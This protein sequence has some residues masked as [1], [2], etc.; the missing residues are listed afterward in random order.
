MKFILEYSCIEVCQKYL[1]M[2]LPHLAFYNN[3]TRLLLLYSDSIRRTEKVAITVFFQ[4]K[5]S[6]GGN[7]YLV[8]VTKIWY[9]ILIFLLEILNSP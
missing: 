6:C 7:Q 4:R 5:D 1:L 9:P 8:S 3:S 2:F